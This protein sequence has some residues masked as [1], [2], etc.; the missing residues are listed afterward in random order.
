MERHKHPKISYVWPVLSGGDRL[1][2]TVYASS[3]LRHGR[4]TTSEL[5]NLLAFSPDARMPGCDRNQL[6]ASPVASGIS[7]EGMCCGCH[8]DEVGRCRTRPLDNSGQKFAF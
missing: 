2:K 6:F 5:L 1:G 7:V 3:A 4:D 8:A